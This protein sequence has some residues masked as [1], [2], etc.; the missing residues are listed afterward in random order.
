MAADRDRVLAR[1][2]EILNLCVPGTYSK[3]ISPRIK[4]RNALAIEDMV[5]DAGLTILKAIAERPNEFR[6]SFASDSTITTSGTVL[7]DHL[8]P[9]FRV[10]ITL[11]SGG[12]VRDGQRLD[13]RKI[14]SYRENPSYVY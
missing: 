13:Y 9:P 6:Q 3:T 10:L 12:T 1:V 7:P 2:T 5:D 4:T 14:E 8:G 11:S